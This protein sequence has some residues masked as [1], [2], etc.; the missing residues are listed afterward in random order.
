MTRFWPEFSSIT[1]V[2]SRVPTSHH[3]Y[4][5]E[6]TFDYA[7]ANLPYAKREASMNSWK[8]R[9]SFGNQLLGFPQPEE[10]QNPI[11]PPGDQLFATQPSFTSQVET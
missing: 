6:A 9:L 8:H 1:E 10:N 11:V 3:K 4:G 2:P 5:R 7:M